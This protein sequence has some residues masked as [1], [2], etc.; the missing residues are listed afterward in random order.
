[1]RVDGKPIRIEGSASVPVAIGKATFNHEFIVANE[2]TAEA[3]LGLDFLEAKRCVLDL[4]GGKLQI[5]D[6]TVTLKA[7]SSQ[8]DTH[9][10]KVTVLKKTV[11]PPRCEMEVM[12]HI[13]KTW[14][15]EGLQFKELPICVAR[16]ISIPKEQTL[17][18]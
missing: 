13:P 6:Q 12:A 7:K 11:I 2:I 8:S 4:A 10:A 14:L 3:I 17:P 16:S 18:I 5:A 9:C 1:M 15:L